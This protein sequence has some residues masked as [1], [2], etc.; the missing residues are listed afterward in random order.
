VKAAIIGAFVAD[1]ATMPLHWIYSPDEIRG[2]LDGRDPEFFD[3]PSSPFYDYKLGQLSPY[4]EE[5]LPLLESV[6]E[7]GG[8]VVR[9][10]HRRSFATAHFQVSIHDVDMALCYMHCTCMHTR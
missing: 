2:K 8:V 4:G 1:A 5:A 10:V 9:A 6:T 7:H 3:P